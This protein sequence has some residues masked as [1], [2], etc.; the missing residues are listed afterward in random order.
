MERSPA[1]RLGIVEV[2]AEARGRRWHFGEMIAT[3]AGVSGAFAARGVKRG[4]VVMTLVGNRVEWGVTLLAFWRMGAVA[5]PCNTML[6]RKDLELRVAA[7]NPAL[8]VGEERLLGEM[9]DGG[10]GMTIGGVGLV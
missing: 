2:D 10:P 5:L 1:S 7:A 8:C 6:R 9:P 4:D 3:S